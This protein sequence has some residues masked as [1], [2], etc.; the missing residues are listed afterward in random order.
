MK[1]DTKEADNIYNYYIKLED[2]M[3]KYIE[4]KHKKILEENKKILEEKDKIIK[5][6]DEEIKNIKD[7]KYKKYDEAKKVGSIYLL[8][9]DKAN[10]IK[11]GRTKDIDK[12]KKALQTALVDDIK[13]FYEYKTSNDVLLESI[14]HDILSKY[15]SISN[16]EHFYCNIEYMKLIIDIAGNILD[17][18]KSSYEYINRE[19]ILEKIYNRLNIN[20]SEEK[21]ESSNLIKKEVKT[22][23]K[24]ESSNLIKKEDKNLDNVKSYKIININSI[25]RGCAINKK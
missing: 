19:E 22:E 17:I 14:V 24:L 25:I 5:D 13:V 6:K 18:L 16:R 2:V 15:R 21:I 3:T 8:S 20:K 7:I 12:R 4:I 23:E 10:V 1:A 11:C 9:T